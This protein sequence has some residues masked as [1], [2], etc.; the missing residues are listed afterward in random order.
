MDSLRLFAAM[1]FAVSVFLLF[2]AWV[3]ERNP[4]VAPQGT[5][6]QAVTATPSPT[7]PPG[8]TAPVN[9]AAPPAKAGA[10]PR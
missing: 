5:A 7:L 9:P 4:P 2:D 6:Q 3:K 8:A 10:R 1:I